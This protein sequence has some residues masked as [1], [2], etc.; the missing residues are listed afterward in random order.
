MGVRCIPIKYSLWF[1]L[2]LKYYKPLRVFFYIGQGE[3]MNINRTMK[4]LQNAILHKGMIIKINT[5]QFFSEEQERM[6][7]SYRVYTPVLCYSR[8]KG[9]YTTDYEILKT[10]SVS[11]VVFCL[12]DI[13]KAVKEWN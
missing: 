11:E 7:I 8:M 5:N 13:Y 10:C 3:K 1:I 6:I 4:K 9:Y 12:F 2:I